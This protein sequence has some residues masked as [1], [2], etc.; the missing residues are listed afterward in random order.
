[1]WIK[2]WY[3]VSNSCSEPELKY[4]WVSDRET[5]NSLLEW[6]RELVPDY[7][8]YECSFKYGFERIVK[9]PKEYI[10]S[11]RKEYINNIKYANEMLKIIDL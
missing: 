4:K 8:K 2:F 11:L 1:M 9:P 3:T 6:A 7:I 10:D 5:D